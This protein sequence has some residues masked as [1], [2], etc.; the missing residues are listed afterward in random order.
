MVVLSE[1]RQGKTG[2]IG[3]HFRWNLKMDINE[4]FIKENQPQRLKKKLWYQKRKLRGQRAIRWYRLIDTH[5]T[6]ADMLLIVK[7]PT[8]L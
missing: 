8:G 5:K 4:L 6:G 7:S 1:V 2:I 3:H